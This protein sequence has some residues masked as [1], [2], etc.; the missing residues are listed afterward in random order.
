MTTSRTGP[1]SAMRPAYITA[2]R[3]AVS[4]ITPMSW[5]ISITAVP[6]SRAE[7]LQQRD[8]LRLH[9]DVERGGRLVG[10]DQLRLG[11]ER[12]RQH[13]ALAHAAGELVRVAVDAPL[14]RRDADL[15]E[16]LDGA[17]ARA[18]AAFSGRCVRMVS[19]SWS[20]MR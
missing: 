20:P 4:A 1:I 11:A 8:D 15:G 13:D 2:T 12:E 14:R 10:D 3:S 17:V 7:A 6:R 5:V 16:Q 18:C 19:T 9:R